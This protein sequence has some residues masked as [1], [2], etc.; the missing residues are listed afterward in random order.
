[1][2]SLIKSEY[3]NMKKK[4]S[5]ELEMDLSEFQRIGANIEN[6]IFIAGDIFEEESRYC[7]RGRMGLTKYLL[8]PRKFRKHLNHESEV[9]SKIIVKG[10]EKY[11]IYKFKE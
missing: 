4:V 10:N 2:A 7:S 5:C 9:L 6:I 11:I 1:M 8:V 3:D